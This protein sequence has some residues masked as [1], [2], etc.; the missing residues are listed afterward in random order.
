MTEVSIDASRERVWSVLTDFG[1][2]PSWN[3]F[4]RKIIGHPGPNGE[5]R[6]TVK[7]PLFPPVAFD[8]R[9]T[10]LVPGESIGWY[11]VFFKGLLC[12]RHWFELHKIDS[13]GTLMIHFEEFT[14]LLSGIVPTILSGVFGKGYL[15]MNIAL[16]R[17]SERKG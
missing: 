11:A 14:G 4:L 8:A 6:I 1:N 13:E 7:L 2:Y 3:P 12:A 10:S 5:L 9:I 17:E 15:L 16:G